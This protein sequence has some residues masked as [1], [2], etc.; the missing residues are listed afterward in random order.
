MK[1]NKVSLFSGN[2][3][4]KTTIKVK[5]FIH[6]HEII[7]VFSKIHTSNI[8][9]PKNN[10]KNLSYIHRNQLLSTQQHVV[11]ALRYAPQE[12]PYPQGMAIH[13][14]QMKNNSLTSSI[15]I[16]IL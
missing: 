1:R 10:D 12:H 13:W 7:N 5:I 4:S 14:R 8:Q 6:F 2:I 16:K 15:Q 3:Y 11:S 9:I